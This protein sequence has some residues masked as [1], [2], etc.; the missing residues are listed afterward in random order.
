MG[1]ILPTEL[2]INFSPFNPLL[3]IKWSLLSSLRASDPPHF[4]EV[5]MPVSHSPFSLAGQSLPAGSRTRISLELP[6]LYVQ[7]P[8]SLPIIVL[9]GVQPGPVLWVSA[10]I[11]GDEINGI[12]II[13][14]L[15]QTVDPKQL[16][17]TVLAIPIVN[18]FGIIHQSRYLPDR[19]DLNRSFPGSSRGSLAATVANVFLKEVVKRSTHGIDLHTAAIHRNNWPQIR[20]NLED[21]E[22][23]RLAKAFGA[24]L[25]LHSKHRDG[26][27]RQVAG[28]RGKICL[29]YE[30]GEA[31][32]HSQEAITMGTHG[33]LNVMRALKMLPVHPTAKPKPTRVCF[34]DLWVR[35]PQSGMCVLHV[36]LGDR[37]KAGQSLGTLHFRLHKDFHPQTEIE[38][39]APSSGLVIGLSENPLVLKGEALVHLAR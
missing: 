13:K 34:E 19:R 20:A 10:A 23:L 37:V 26:S 36:R 24:H 3:S 28:S 15:L 17:G 33:I 30:A 2:K 9:H 25:A 16:A 11:H 18:I 32:R 12:F 38:L 1:K 8:I 22:T 7:I 5:L 27:L 6:S 29:L 4:S 35:A 31:L 39:P 21:P 14:Q